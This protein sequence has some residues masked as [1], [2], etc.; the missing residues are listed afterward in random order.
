MKADGHRLGGR[1]QGAE[2]GEEKEVEWELNYN[3]N[4][5]SKQKKGFI[6]TITCALAQLEGFHSKVTFKETM[7]KATMNPF[8]CVKQ[9]QD[10]SN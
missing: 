9:S 4:M 6:V 5:K 8:S 10:N 1:Q 7:Y 3:Q 2:L